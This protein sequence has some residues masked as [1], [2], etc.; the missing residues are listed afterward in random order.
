MGVH[1]LPGDG[2]AETRVLAKALVGTV[3]V[4]TLEDPLEGM[5]GNARAIIIDDDL[6]A[7]L[8]GRSARP[9]RPRR[10]A[11]R[12]PPPRGEKERAFSKRLVS[13]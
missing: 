4:E 7:L 3:G 11:M 5:G 1:D 8:I 10:S 13:T 6:D 12:T 2:Q 9:D